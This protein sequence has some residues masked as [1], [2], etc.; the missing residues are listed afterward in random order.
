MNKTSLLPPS[1]T[2]FIRKAERGG[3]RL[4]ALPVG[5]RHLWD[6]DSC[7]VQLLPYLAWALS[8]DRWDQNW[9]EETKRQVIRDSWDIHRH[10]GTIKAIRRVVEPFGYVIRVTEWWETNETPGTFRL[11]IGVLDIGIT[12]E[13]Y[14]EVERL[15]SDARPV[16]RHLIGLNIIQDVPGYMYTGGIAYDGDIITIYPAE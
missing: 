14:R 2:E 8:V 13:M 12:E 7:P 15:V 6:P 11:D 16:S 5:I 3:E 4:M 1:A 9:P 10:K